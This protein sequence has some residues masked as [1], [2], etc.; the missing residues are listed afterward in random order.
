[1]TGVLLVTKKKADGQPKKKEPTSL[2]LPPETLRKINQIAKWK[3]ISAYLYIEPLIRSALN[4]DWVELK[5]EIAET[6]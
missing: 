5:K 1:M 2:R 6:E 3:G 4:K